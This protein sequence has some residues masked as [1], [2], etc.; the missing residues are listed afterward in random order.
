MYLK[1]KFMYRQVTLLNKS[2]SLVIHLYMN[3]TI[4]S[5]LRYNIPMPATPVHVFDY[6]VVF[7]MTQLI[8]K[9]HKN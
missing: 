4:K 2:N 8:A 9:Q 7:I 5:R 1:L 6:T 3:M